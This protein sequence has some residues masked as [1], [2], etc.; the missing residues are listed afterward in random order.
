MHNAIYIET[1]YCKFHCEFAQV[2]QNII[3]LRVE[4]V[5]LTETLIILLLE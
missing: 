2:S 4:Y 1:K 5:R 3:H